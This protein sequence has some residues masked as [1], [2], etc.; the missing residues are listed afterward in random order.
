MHTADS[1]PFDVGV[2]PKPPEISMQI[3]LASRNPH[4]L[5]EIRQLLPPQIQVIP[6][7]EL[8][9]GLDIPET[10][11]SFRENAYAKAKIVADFTGRLSLADDSGLQVDALNGEPGI[12]SARYAG[13]GA[14]DE[15]NNRLLLERMAGI[16]PER[17]TAQFVCVIALAEPGEKAYFAEGILKG[18]IALE[19]HGRH[20]FGYDPLFIVPEYNHT[21]AQLGPEI[22]NRISHRAQAMNKANQIL[23][24]LSA[25]MLK[26]FLCMN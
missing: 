16:P 15:D 26:G 20:G 3:V 10:G 14:K 19:P 5:I 21:F 6:V 23:L 9:P 13:P 17:R 7:S 24:G 2:S 18:V 11:R 22:K 4:K 1:G 12:Y 8:A 25:T